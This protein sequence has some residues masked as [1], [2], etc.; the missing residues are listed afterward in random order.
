VTQLT[1]VELSFS[2]AGAR[3]LWEDLGRRAR[4]HYFLSPGFVEVWLDELP[5]RVRPRLCAVCRAGEP[6]AAFFL[7]SRRVFRHGVLPSRARFLNTSG[8]PRYDELTLEHNAVLCEPGAAPTLREWLELLPGDWD[9][10]FLPALA[11]DAFPASAL[12]EPVGSLR[13]LVERVVEAPVV[14]LARAR[15]AKGGYASLLGA[16]TR[17][18]IRRAERGYGALALEVAESTGQA[19]EILAELAELHQRHWR[20]RGEPGVFAD[21]WFVKFHQTL[22]ERRFA[23]GELQL[24]RVRSRQRTIGCLYNFVWRGS[25][26]F[27]QSGLVEEADPRL[28]PGYVCHARAV[29]LNAALGHHA[30]DFLAGAAR[31]KHSLATANRSMIWARI[32]RPLARF[33]LERRMRELQASW[34]AR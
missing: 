8:D 10:L 26:L 6:V 13:V 23:H 32:Q 22:V 24:L 34:S 20:A 28:K 29:E 2:A 3:S 27:Y 14:E 1:L 15:A 9:E 19:M 21:P 30:Y 4:C 31:Y 12:S 17:A 33:S 5:L 11:D 18:Q 16:S 7:G 25:V